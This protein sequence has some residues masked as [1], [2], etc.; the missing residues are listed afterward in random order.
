MKYARPLLLAASTVALFISAC[1][2]PAD[3]DVPTL[4]PQFGTVDDDRATFVAVNSAHTHVYTAGVTSRLGDGTLFLRR[5]NQDGSLSWER[6]SEPLSTIRVGGVGTDAAGN[7]YVA[8]SGTAAT[9]SKLNKTGSLLWRKK[10]AADNTS[11]GRVYVSAFVAD[12]S[13][14]SYVALQG[15]RFADEG[16]EEDGSQLRKYD[17]TGKLL[18]QRDFGEYDANFQDLAVGS[19]GS[20]Y[21]LSAGSIQAILMTRYS[22]G[23]T[24]LWQ[25]PIDVRSD[26]SVAVGGN[27]IY[28]A[29]GD[30]EVDSNTFNGLLTKYNAAGVRQW[31]R[32]TGSFFIGGG[33][34]ADSAGN[35]YL[36]ET[37][38]VSV[39]GESDYDLL[40]RK[41][42]AAGALSWTYQPKLSS[43]KEYGEDVA[44]RNAG[45]IYTVGS[46]DGK[47]NGTN[48]G[49]LDAYVF[50]LNGQGQKVWSR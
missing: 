44:V 15:Y 19:D 5:Y 26:V 39:V 2:T 36:T 29:G 47:V 8:Y 41:Y 33:V 40:V 17:T 9:L 31:Q 7:A 18:W 45:E 38:V 48:N 4:E 43:T 46:T 13:G 14:N 42:T 24:T 1:S 23:G 49:G 20:L 32:V 12:S 37:K 50:R 25:V 27:A 21:S 30:Y 11:Y 28:V 22:A 16:S 35:V 10:L 6:R 3:L 34:S